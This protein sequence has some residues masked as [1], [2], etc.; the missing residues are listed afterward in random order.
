M[1]AMG[2]AGGGQSLAFGDINIMVPEGTSPENA[3]DIAQMIV[4]MIGAEVRR[5]LTMESRPRGMLN[6]GA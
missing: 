2:G 1:A 6:S 3:N 4:P 5:I